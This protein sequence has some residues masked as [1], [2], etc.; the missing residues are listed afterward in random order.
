MAGFAV[1]AYAQA[2]SAAPAAAPTKVATIQVQAAILS[3]A[4]GKK[5]QNDLTNK[6]NGRKQALEKKQSEISGL[7]EQLKRGSATMNQDARDKLARDIDAGQ[8]ALKYDGEEFEADVQQEEN[9]IMQDLG[10]KM[11]DVIIKYSTQNSIAMVIDVTQQGPV[12]WADPAADITQEII[13]LY[14]QAH[15]GT[16]APASVPPAKPGPLLSTPPKQ[17]AP[18]PASPPKTSTP[19]AAPKKQ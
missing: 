7:Q 4:D 15:P 2:Q 9:K 11:M 12:L 18:P 8:R 5:A 14:D 3:T 17:A 6:F 19:P 10:S 13:R 1:L 16:A